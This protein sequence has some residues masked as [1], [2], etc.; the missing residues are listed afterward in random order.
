V[1]ALA[2]AS[3]AT[4]F[5]TVPDPRRAASVVSPL[6]A[7]LALIVTALLANHRSVLAIAEWG[8]R[9]DPSLLATLGFPTDR[10]PCQST[11]QRLLRHLDSDALAATLAAHIAPS[12]VATP[13][14]QGVAID[15]KAQRGRLRFRTEGGLVHALSAV[16]QA[17]GLVLAHEPITAQGDKAEAELSV[18]PLLVARIDWRHRVLTG[19]ALFCQRTLCRQ[20]R[21]A[22]G[23]S[24]LLV[25]ENQPTLH[26]AI[27]LLFDP[28][29]EINALPLID[30]RVAETWARGHGRTNEHRHLTA[31][32]DLTDY[33]DWPGVA[34][35]FR[36]EHAWHEHGAPHRAVRYGITSLTPT[37]ADADRLLALRRGHWTIEHAVHRQKD[38]ALGEDA[39]LIHLGQGPT[40]LALLRDAALTVFYQAGIR[41]VAARLRLHAQ[42]PAYAVALVI[43]APSTRA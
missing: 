2:P 27:A 26:E 6:A 34:Q 21:A 42:Y 8:S 38:V 29:P 16:C 12:S 37:Q 28:P 23:N 36:R 10:T 13:P 40:V 35:V 7:V 5:A 14:F 11:M 31:S 3:L 30:R 1:S 4:A 20:I 18:A 32:T 17:S 15:G 43:T 19:D 25:K 9:Q 33:L 39:S 41:Q 24:L 22:D